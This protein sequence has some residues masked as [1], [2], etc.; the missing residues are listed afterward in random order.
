MELCHTHT[1]GSYHYGFDILSSSSMVVLYRYKCLALLFEIGWERC[2]SSRLLTVRLGFS[3][4]S[5]LYQNCCQEY[6]EGHLGA[7]GSSGVVWDL[8][9]CIF[10]C[11]FLPVLAAIGYRLALDCSLLSVLAAIGYR[12]L[13]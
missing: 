1:G 3:S 4:V 10:N 12:A 6:M 8:L 2:S 13:N 11:S 5:M 9:V 7:S